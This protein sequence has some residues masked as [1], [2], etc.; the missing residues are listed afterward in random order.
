MP[1]I[2][3]ALD[4]IGKASVKSLKLALLQK[5]T[6][7]ANDGTN[8]SSSKF[9]SGNL[10]NSVSAKVIENRETLQI[11]ML[12]Y[13]RWVNDGRQPIKYVPIEPLIKWIDNKAQVDSSFRQKFQD[14]IKTKSSIRAL[15]FAIS[16]SIKKRGIKPTFFFDQ[17]ATDYIF[18]DVD[19][20]IEQYLDSLE[21]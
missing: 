15:A 16:A 9:A 8:Y 21:F 4:A 3:E 1:T 2:I 5:Y 17:V 12:D 19:A 6:S 14:A 13:W 10:Y 20:A 11:E 7:T 18:E